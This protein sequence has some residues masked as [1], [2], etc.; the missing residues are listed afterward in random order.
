MSDVPS[1]KVCNRVVESEF[2]SDF[3]FRYLVDND[4]SGT[5]S[6]LLTQYKDHFLLEDSDH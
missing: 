4:S 2:F 6:F 5:K 3:R 1:G